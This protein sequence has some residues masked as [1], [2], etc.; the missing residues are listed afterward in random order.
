[1]D[2]D[3]DTGSL[4]Q[5]IKMCDCDNEQSAK[6][7]CTA[8][9][10]QD[11]SSP[12]REYTIERYDKKDSL[13]VCVDPAHLELTWTFQLWLKERDIRAVICFSKVDLSLILNTYLE[14][15]I[16]HQLMIVGPLENWKGVNFNLQVSELDPLDFESI[17]R[18]LA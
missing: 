16:P 13:L 17:L 14:Y 3:P 12:N 10:A 5:V 2:T 18:S 15:G 11:D 8:L 9:S 6:Q 7:V 1:M 4:S